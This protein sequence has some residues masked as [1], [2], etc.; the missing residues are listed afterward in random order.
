LLLLH[1]IVCFEQ[2][3]RRLFLATEQPD[4]VSHI[5]C[6][7]TTII[8]LMQQ[9]SMLETTVM[10]K[11]CLVLQAMYELCVLRDARV[12][13]CC[14]LLPTEQEAYTKPLIENIAANSVAQYFNQLARKA[15]AVVLDLEVNCVTFA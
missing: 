8:C 4:E 9:D 10:H 6:M 15:E 5:Y 2:V 13:Y 14:A 1:A 3:Y 12:L 11:Y 7:I